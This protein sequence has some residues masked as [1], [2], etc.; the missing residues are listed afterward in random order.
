M[1]GDTPYDVKA[2]ARA[3]VRIIALRVRRLEDGELDGAAEVYADP[4]DLLRR[5]ETSVAGWPAG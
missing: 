3:G 2:A 4:A 5:Y 1:I